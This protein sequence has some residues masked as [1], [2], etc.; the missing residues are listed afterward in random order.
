MAQGGSGR[1]GLTKVREDAR[2]L[3]RQ[4]GVI[5]ARCGV[6]TDRANTPERA[7]GEAKKGRGG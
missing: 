4:L 3:G 1:Q 6:V 5:R 2:R 7:G